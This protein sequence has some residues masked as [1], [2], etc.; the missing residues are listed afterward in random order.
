MKVKNKIFKDNIHFH[1][2]AIRAAQ[3]F[4]SLIYGVG[5]GGGSKLKAWL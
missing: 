3:S 4:K 2:M 5:G 1:S